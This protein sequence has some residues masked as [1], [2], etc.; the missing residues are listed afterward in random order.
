MPEASKSSGCF[1]R[2]MRTLSKAR[3]RVLSFITRYGV[4]F[5][6]PR[7]GHDG[8]GPRETTAAGEFQRLPD[9]HR[10]R[11]RRPGQKRCTQA[12]QHGDRRGTRA[13]HARTHALV[14]RLLAEKVQ[15]A[16]HAASR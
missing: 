11:T 5:P 8:R 13:T 9:D 1:S 15:G 6:I 7:S 2:T 14:E 4:P 10:P 3:P 16:G 12:L